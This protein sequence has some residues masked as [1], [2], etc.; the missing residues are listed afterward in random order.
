MQQVR[1]A[2]AAGPPG[3][4]GSVGFTIGSIGVS[5]ASS[6]LCRQACNGSCGFRRGH[7]RQKSAPQSRPQPSAETAGTAFR[8]PRHAAPRWLR[9]CVGR[10]HVSGLRAACHGNDACSRTPVASCEGVPD[11]HGQRDFA[12]RPAVAM[13]GATSTGGL[14]HPPSGCR[15]SATGHAWPLVR[16]QLQPPSGVGS[17]RDEGIV[18]V[19]RSFKVDRPIR[20]SSMVMIQKRTTTC[21]SF[22]P[23]FSK[24]WCS[25][26]ILSRRRPSP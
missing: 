20:H 16:R 3:A 21:V 5:S 26:A 1:I 2:S 12:I 7:R 6:C 9:A 24:W 23:L 13:P 8:G 15:A 18:R 17:R 4:S 25:G 10:R 19:H 11:V 14:L 22:Q